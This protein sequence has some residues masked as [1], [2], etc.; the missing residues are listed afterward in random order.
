MFGLWLTVQNGGDFTI[1]GMAV[2]AILGAIYQ[3]FGSPAAHRTFHLMVLPHLSTQLRDP[4]LV[5]RA[6]AILEELKRDTGDSI[7]I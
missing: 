1:D 7:V 6:T 3:E 4:I 2:E 5:E